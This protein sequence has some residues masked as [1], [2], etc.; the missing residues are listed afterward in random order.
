M[1]KS[2]RVG[3]L[4][5][6]LVGALVSLFVFREVGR[7]KKVPNMLAVIVDPV[8]GSAAV[9]R[10][11]ADCRGKQG[12]YGVSRTRAIADEF[13]PFLDAKTP[14]LVVVAYFDSLS[15]EMLTGDSAK[16]GSDV[17]RFL[18]S[19]AGRATTQRIAPQRED[20]SVFTPHVSVRYVESLVNRF[21]LK[22]RQGFVSRVAGLEKFS[23]SQSRLQMPV[24][25]SSEYVEYVKLLLVD[26]DWASDRA[27]ERGLGRLQDSMRTVIGA[28]DAKRELVC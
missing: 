10:V 11:M 1:T 16:V 27:I 23:D 19:L 28:D 13:G 14:D 5:A 4:A 18:V 8:Q 2:Q 7:N 21:S 6:V 20:V 9:N 3:L 12:N 17:S 22:R 24:V 26:A 25:S 15:P